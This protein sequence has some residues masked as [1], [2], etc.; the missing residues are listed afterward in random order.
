[1]VSDGCKGLQWGRPGTFLFWQNTW[2]PIITEILK[3]ISVKFWK[4]M[5]DFY[6]NVRNHELIIKIQMH[7]I[8]KKTR[9]I[10]FLVS[11]KTG[12]FTQTLC[13]QHINTFCHQYYQLVVNWNNRFQKLFRTIKNVCFT[14]E[15]KTRNTNVFIQHENSDSKKIRKD[16]K[17]FRANSDWIRKYHRIDYH[18]FFV[19]SSLSPSERI[20][21]EFLRCY[22][23]DDTRYNPLKQQY[24]C[25][26]KTIQVRL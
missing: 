22:I 6:Q 16:Q 26:F 14:K 24:H 2:Y 11:T 17:R 1:M 10:I 23:S 7:I 8:S 18:R 19:S 9:H 21:L 15:K 20:V 4:K 13:P 3:W 5:S 25:L 12:K